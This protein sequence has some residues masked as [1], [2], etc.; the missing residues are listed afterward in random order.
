[1][2]NT[3]KYTG[4][5]KYLRAAQKVAHFFIASLPEDYIAHWDFRV[6]NLDNEPRDTSAAACAASGLLEIAALL[7]QEEG[8]MYKNAAKKIIISLTQNYSTY[9]E[10][11]YEGML[12]QGTGN[13]PA[14]SNVNVSLIYGDYFYVECLAK[15]NGWNHNIF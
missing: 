9:D 2:A 10:P 7:P 6:P 5:I 14:D 15:L 3:Y 8:R 4:D 1:M 11:Y 13:K 12:L